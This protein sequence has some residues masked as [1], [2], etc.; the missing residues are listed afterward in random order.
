MD[1]ILPWIALVLAVTISVIAVIELDNRSDEADLAVPT[2]IQPT[3]S[4]PAAPTRTLGPAAETAKPRTT[5]GRTATPPR[6]PTPAPELTPGPTDKSRGPTPRTGGDSLG[7][8]LAVAA[9]AL[10]LRTRLNLGA[11]SY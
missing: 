11:G 4:T 2:F 8:G 5:P 9:L 1:R 7:L 10:I 3:P 6:T